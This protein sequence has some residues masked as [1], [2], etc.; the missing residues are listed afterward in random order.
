MTTTIESFGQVVAVRTEE[1]TSRSGSACFGLYR[2][3]AR[4]IR[5]ENG[6][7]LVKF[8][9]GNERVVAIDLI[10]T[11]TLSETVEFVEAQYTTS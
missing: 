10:E 11:A 6:Q 5:V 9:A 4:L 7:A 8:A 2:V 1:L 3:P